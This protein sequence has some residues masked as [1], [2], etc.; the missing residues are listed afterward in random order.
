MTAPIS[1]EALTRAASSTK[2]DFP[3]GTLHPFRL[4]YAGSGIDR[5]SDNVDDGGDEA[6]SKGNNEAL[7]PYPTDRPAVP[8]GP[9]VNELVVARSRSSAP[10]YSV[11]LAEVVAMTI[12]RPRACQ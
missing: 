10:R 2:A 8:Q 4:F 7:P 5:A 3:Q 9:Q 1:A 12:E 6:S 11:I